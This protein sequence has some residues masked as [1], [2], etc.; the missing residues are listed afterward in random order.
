ML[1]LRNALAGA[2]YKVS[3]PLLAGHGSTVEDL[4]AST[5]RE[6]YDTVRV[7]FAE[8]RR[9][10]DK[11]YVAGISLGGLLGLKLAIDEGW[12][13]RA[14]ALMSTPIRLP[15][16]VRIQLGIVKHTP[17]RWM[18]RSAKKKWDWSIDEPVAR[19]EYKQL[20]LP[21]TP[22][23]S[24]Y[25]ILALQEELEP[26]LG[27]ITNPMILLYGEKDRTSPPYNIDLLKRS[28]ASDIVET[29]TFKRSQHIVTMD[30]DKDAVMRQTLDFFEKFA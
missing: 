3:A 25:E 2:G 1:P 18:I 29:A 6:W 21:R 30:W 7:A 8:L 20:A 27:E 14:L 5:W 23:S 22:L 19:E 11:T 28:V 9:E 24:A 26:R 10:V 16:L 12:G 15:L 13:V 4:E 17:L